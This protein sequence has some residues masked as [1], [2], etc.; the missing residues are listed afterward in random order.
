MTRSLL[1]SI[2]GN[3][4]KDRPVFQTL[5]DEID[6]VFDEFR[7]AMTSFS[8]TPIAKDAAWLT[9][10]IDVSETDEAIEVLA[11]IP[12]VKEKDIDV[13]V[14]NNV[15]VIKGE[16]SEEHE[17]K[18]KDYHLIECS[19]GR[20]VRSIPLGFDV[21]TNDVKADFDSGVLKVKIKKP[22]EIA[23]QTKK[24]PINKAA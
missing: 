20:Y 18:K 10:R 6:R 17:E 4:K 14:T 23:E 22:A 7:G 11:E 13:T 3:D 15:L 8:D 19:Q 9:P 2:F 5:H 24:I 21:E 16:K 1:P 12:G